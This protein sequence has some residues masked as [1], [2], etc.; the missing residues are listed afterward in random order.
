MITE[1][2]KTEIV[3][4][5]KNQE[6]LKNIALDMELAA[7]TISNFMRK[8]HPNL[9]KWSRNKRET[10]LS[11]LTK[12]VQNSL[13]VSDT[14]AQ[15]LVENLLDR[16]ENK[17]RTTKEVF[18]VD[19]LDIVIPTHCPYLGIPLDYNTQNYRQDNYPSFD[20]IDPNKGYIPGNVVL[21]SWRANR[22]KNN[23]TSEEHRRIADVMDAQTCVVRHDLSSS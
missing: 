23:G 4:R 13:G 5:Y 8:Y 12:K 15:V 21:C 22:I 10:L 7:S 18:S 14:F 20:R 19:L 3:T 11:R 6:S 16:L 2:Q 9:L 17:R 1:A